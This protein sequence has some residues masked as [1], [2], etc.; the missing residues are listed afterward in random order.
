MGVLL[1]PVGEHQTARR[2]LFWNVGIVVTAVV[3]N[4]LAL[5]V[6]ASAMEGHVVRASLVSWLL[7]SLALRVSKIATSAGSERNYA[8]LTG[9]AATL[10]VLA[11][12]VA[13]F[14]EARTTSIGFDILASFLYVIAIRMEQQ[15]DRGLRNSD[16]LARVHVTMTL[17]AGLWVRANSN[18]HG[19]VLKRD[20]SAG[21]YGPDDTGVHAR[22]AAGVSDCEYS[23]DRHPR[24][25]SGSHSLSA[26]RRR[27]VVRICE[28]C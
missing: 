16:S 6:P 4:W 22:V 7:V 12:S 24:A 21:V 26:R 2:R 27:S 10:L 8:N 9:A 13:A 25:A 20:S 23:D 1:F 14:V 11:S 18:P 19:A 17:A 5:F 3:E 15:L 28:S